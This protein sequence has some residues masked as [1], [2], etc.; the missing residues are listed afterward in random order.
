MPKKKPGMTPKE[1]RRKFEEEVE[2]LR[3][4]GELD[5]DEAARRMDRLVRKAGTADHSD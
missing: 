4:A 1:Q 5:P 3:A 2:R